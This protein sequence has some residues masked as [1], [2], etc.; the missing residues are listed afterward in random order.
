MSEALARA[1]LAAVVPDPWWLGGVV[2]RRVETLAVP[3]G[4]HP[5][6]HLVGRRLDA[7]ALVLVW[8]AASVW[9]GSTQ[10]QGLARVRRL[11]PSALV[12]GDTNV[13]VSAGGDDGALTATTPD[14][15]LVW[16]L[17][18]ALG[19]SC[20]A[21]LDR[22]DVLARFW[23][24][25]VVEALTSAQEGL[26]SVKALVRLDP[27]LAGALT[28]GRLDVEAPVLRLGTVDWASAGALEEVNTCSDE[29]VVAM[30]AWPD[31][32]PLE[33]MGA[34]MA[35]AVAAAQLPHAEALLG[36]LTVLDEDVADFMRMVL[37]SRGWVRT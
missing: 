31:D 34:T 21:N 4:R 36:H 35:L 20:S 16:A 29:Q 1:A 14:G 26:D 30:M 19:K 8:R 32:E 33:W 28:R 22:G 37:V 13:L 6:L 11:Q 27:A 7:E 25:S 3:D 24:R 12:V 10:A 2:G 18:R 15:L 5:Y 23:I 17:E 9:P